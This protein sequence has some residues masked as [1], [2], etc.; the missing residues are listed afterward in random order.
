MNIRISELVEK[1]NKR[2]FNEDELDYNTYLRNY[3]TMQTGG[4]AAVFARPSYP[5]E[6]SFILSECKKLD[7][8]YFIL[9]GGS[10][11]VASDKPMDLLILSTERF[12][13][14]EPEKDS[15]DVTFGSGT[16]IKSITAY[17]LENELTGFEK[18]SGLPGTI[19]G[20]AF[21]NARCYGQDI[22][23]VIKS[24]D[25]IDAGTGKQE[26]YV[27]NPEDW[28]YKKSPFQ[29]MD[30]LIT[31]VTL[32]GLKKG[33]AADIKKE[34]DSYVK[35]REDKGHFRFPSAGSVFK[36]NHD[37]GK[38]SG[39]LIDEA[40]LKGEEWGGAQV[41]PWHGNFIINKG[42]ATCSDIKNLVAMVQETVKSKT[43]FLLEPEIIF[44][45]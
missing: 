8:R 7:I 21:M 2:G 38:P 4:R 1:F 15:A 36:N 43:G 3:T 29:K 16:R 25:Y 12:I 35:D 44:L 10:N 27:M 34:S 41:A 19:G 23:S 33:N 17:C 45:E 31:A 20:A 13:S 26:H 9:G 39:V 32:T 24:V 42:D 18:F 11:I 22:C 14:C 6:A 40:G 28:N 37:F 30:A 5:E